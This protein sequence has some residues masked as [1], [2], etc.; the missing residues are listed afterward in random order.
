MTHDPSE[1]LNIILCSLAAFIVVVIFVLCTLYC[2]PLGRSWVYRGRPV[3][4]GLRIVRGEDLDLDREKEKDGDG[5]GGEWVRDWGLIRLLLTSVWYDVLFVLYGSRVEG[6]GTGMVWRLSGV[7][8]FYFLGGSSF[9]IIL[10]VFVCVRRVVWM[11]CD[12]ILG[13]TS[14]LIK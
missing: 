1:T 14:R 2:T 4:A 11:W 12:V 10:G 3:R 9:C 8:Y 5:D 13:Q 7:C 6:M